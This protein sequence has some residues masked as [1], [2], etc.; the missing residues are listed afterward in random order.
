MQRNYKDITAYYYDWYMAPTR[1]WAENF[2]GA[3]HRQQMAHRIGDPTMSVRLSIRAGGLALAFVLALALVSAAPS[4]PGSQVLSAQ[5]NT[6]NGQFCPAAFA[7][8]LPC[9]PNT[10]TSI[11]SNFSYCSDGSTVPSTQGCP[12]GTS[13]VVPASNYVYC[14]DG[15]VVSVDQTCPTTAPA[16]TSVAP[17]V[18]MV[19]VQPPQQLTETIPLPAEQYVMISDPWNLVASVS[20]PDQLLVFDPSIGSY[21]QTTML[22]P[23]QSAW[24][25]S[26]YG[27]TATLTAIPS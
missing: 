2:G 6:G 7:A 1:F 27:G 15:S 21:S 19:A 20:G 10:P 16:A 14:P 26:F 25:V 17:A 24:A 5:S 3:A 23:G 4:M 13:A 22:M 11:N 18:N 8:G 12:A 9:N